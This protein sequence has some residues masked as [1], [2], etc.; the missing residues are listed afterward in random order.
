VVPL[1]GCIWTMF[2][3]TD[4]AWLLC[5]G[6]TFNATTYP[7]LNAL[8]GGNTLPDLVN[9]LPAGSGLA[10]VG[11]TAG[12]LTASTLIAHTH[13]GGS[14]TH[15]GPSHTHT[16]AAHTHPAPG[17][18]GF[19]ELGSSSSNWTDSSSGGTEVVS[20]TPTGS[21]T[22][23]ATGSSSGTTGTGSATTGSTG[24]GSS[25]SILNPV[26]GGLWYMRAL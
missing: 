2:T 16:S 13:P 19:I 26:A 20:S 12:S 24:S 15:G 5:N 17:G 1:G 23:G 11:A 21:T 10:A 8:L 18:A 9:N 25:F 6:G 7:L 14:H 3:I 4:I 22:P